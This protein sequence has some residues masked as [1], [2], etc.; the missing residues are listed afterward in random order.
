ML[1]NISIKRPGYTVTHNLIAHK[2]EDI[3]RD[4]FNALYCITITEAESLTWDDYVSE[5]NR[6]AVSGW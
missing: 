1:Y 4:Y 5:E 3:P 2:I 6:N